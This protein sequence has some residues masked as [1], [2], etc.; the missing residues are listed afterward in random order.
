MKKYLLFAAIVLPCL[1][2]AQIN[3]D[4][5]PKKVNVIEIETGLSMEDNFNRAAQVLAEKS[6]EIAQMHKEIGQLVTGIITIKSVK[7]KFNI[8]AKEGMIKLTGDF[9]MELTNLNTLEVTDFGYSK[10]SN[11]GMKGSAG[12]KS[13]QNLVELAQLLAPT[14]SKI[15]FLVTK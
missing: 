14:N 13:F 7:H 9:A 6:W 5:I 1:C 15:R 3:V 4:T 11:F 12:K 8:L 2:I 10:I